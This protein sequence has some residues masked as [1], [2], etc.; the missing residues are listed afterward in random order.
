[1]PVSV[2]I[3]YSIDLPLYDAGQLT[4]DAAA[5]DSMMY[6]DWCGVDLP[7]AWLE[8]MHSEA[9]SFLEN[10]SARGLAWL[11]K[12]VSFLLYSWRFSH[13]QW[14]AGLHSL[15]RKRK[16]KEKKKS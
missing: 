4:V 1:M 3:K 13:D 2:G 10:W 9:D 12:K 7:C 14:A 8:L 15:N 11:M 5:D 6:G 16:K